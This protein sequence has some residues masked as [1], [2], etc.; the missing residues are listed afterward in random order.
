MRVVRPIVKPKLVQ[1]TMP[2]VLTL[3]CNLLGQTLGVLG[4]TKLPKFNVNLAANVRQL[5][6]IIVLAAILMTVGIAECVL[7][8]GLFP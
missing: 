6:P 5:P 7:Q 1:T 3:V 8:P 2:N 4:E